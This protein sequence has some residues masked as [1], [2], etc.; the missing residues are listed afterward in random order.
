MKHYRRLILLVAGLLLLA[1]CTG[2][3]T[4]IFENSTVCG[5]IQIELTNTQ[6]DVTETYQVPTG[7][8]L[9]IGVAPDV[10]YRYVID[11]SAAQDSPQGYRCIAVQRGEVSVPNGSSTRFN[12][13]AATPTPSAAP[14][15]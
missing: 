15:G 6:N 5:T 11:Y 13:T 4:L 7:E 1:G 10:T 9:T 3:S 14:G 2:Q 12:L 8:T